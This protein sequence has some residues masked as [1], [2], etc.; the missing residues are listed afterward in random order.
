MFSDHA[1]YVK[2][3]SPFDI[4]VIITGCSGYI[5]NKAAYEYRS[6]ESDTGFYASGTGEAMAEE[7]VKLLNAIK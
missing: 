2:E 7:Y 3:N 6:Y 4:T 1:E 5:P